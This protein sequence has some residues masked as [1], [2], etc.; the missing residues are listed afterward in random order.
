[1]DSDC[2]A[3]D[4]LLSSIDFFSQ[5]LHLEQIVEYGFMI[6]NAFMC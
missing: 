4:A 2:T 1:M 5:N 6:F 3:L